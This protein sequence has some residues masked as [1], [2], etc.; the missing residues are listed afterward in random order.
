[1]R[2]NLV[3][4][5]RGGATSISEAWL[6][7]KACLVRTW[8][9]H[10]FARKEGQNAKSSQVG[11]CRCL[12]HRAFRRCRG[13]SSLTRVQ[14]A[15]SR[16]D[17]R[18]ARRTCAIFMGWPQLLLVSRRLART[19]LVLVRLCLAHGFWLGWRLWLARLARWLGSWRLGAWRLARWPRLA[20]LIP[21]V[22]RKTTAG[23]TLEFSPPDRAKFETSIKGRSLRPLT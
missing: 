14:L 5:M 16:C 10:D 21:R 12:G 15:R 2:R 4:S 20:S 18:A 19:G 9:R 11:K 6:S 3:L 1:M 23:S 13:R 17:A 8:S 22:I 7:L